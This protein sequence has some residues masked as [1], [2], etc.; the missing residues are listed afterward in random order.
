MS[1]IISTKPWYKH[2]NKSQWRA[3]PGWAIY[4]MVLISF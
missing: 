1:E 2:L 3:Q 4:W